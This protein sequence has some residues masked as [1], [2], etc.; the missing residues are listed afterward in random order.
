M[1]SNVLN[2]L[3]VITDM[4]EKLELK[5]T[6]NK[7]IFNLDKEDFNKIFDSLHSNKQ[8]RVERPKETFT[9]TIENVDFIFNMNN[10]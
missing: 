6:S 4:I 9:I 3:A 7:V 8:R 2:Q 10:V 1:E 5:T